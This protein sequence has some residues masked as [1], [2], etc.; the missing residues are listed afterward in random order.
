M[1][2]ACVFGDRMATTEIAR[3]LAIRTRSG[4][5]TRGDRYATTIRTYDRRLNAWRVDFITLADDATS[6]HPIAHRQGQGIVMAG[7]PAN[8]TPIRWR[9]QAVTANSFHC[10]AAERL[11]DGKPAA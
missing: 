3:R 1:P 7:E 11:Q 10:S 6:A 8:D 4:L 5:R 2:L 9:Y